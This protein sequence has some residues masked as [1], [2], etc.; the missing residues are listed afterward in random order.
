MKIKFTRA[1]LNAALD[2]DLDNVEYVKDSR[3]GFEVPTSCPGVP[4]DVLQPIK[5]WSNPDDY[6]ISADNLASMFI[7][8]FKRYQQ[9]VS[10]AVNA[11]SPKPSSVN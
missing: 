3:F 8:N 9:G 6:H 7:Q 11:S 10:E 2:G 5:T 4:S 1:M